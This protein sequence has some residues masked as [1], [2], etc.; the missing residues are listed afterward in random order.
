MINSTNKWVS[1][2]AANTS[3]MVPTLA[4]TST[5]RACGTV[6][7]SALYRLIS[8]TVTALVL[9]VSAPVSMPTAALER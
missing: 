6:I 9:W 7:R 3:A 1:T 4:Q 8:M 2:A 5:G